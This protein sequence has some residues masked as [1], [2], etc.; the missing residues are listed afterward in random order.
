MPAPV[1][2]AVLS[3][4]PQVIAIRAAAIDG[5]CGPWSTDN[6]SAASSSVASPGAGS[7]PRISSQIIAGRLVEPIRSWTGW[8]RSSIS[9][10]AI[11]DTDVPH[12]W[13]TS[14]TDVTTPSW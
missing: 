8:P 6:T 9:P 7:E 4:T 1:A 13:A 14:S 5:A 11:R 10:G 12:H 3:P 2:I